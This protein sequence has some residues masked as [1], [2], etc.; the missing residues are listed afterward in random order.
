MKRSSSRLLAILAAMALFIC[1]LPILAEEAAEDMPL[2]EAGMAEMDAGEKAEEILPAPVLEASPEPSEVPTA[3]IAPEVTNEIADIPATDATAVPDGEAVP[4][5]TEEPF[6][7]EVT[8]A[9]EDPSKETDGEAVN[10]E[11][12]GESAAE[13]GFKL[14]AEAVHLGVGEKFALGT[15]AAGEVSYI[16]GNPKIASVSGDGVV[17]AKR[18]GETTILAEAGGFSAECHVTVVKAPTKVTLS[19]RKLSLGVGQSAL[20]EA[21]LNNGNESAVSFSSSKPGVALVDAEGRVEAISVGKATITAKSYNGKKASCTV[22]VLAAPSRI[23]LDSR[24]LVLPAG[25]MRQ[26]EVRL[27]SNAA[28]ELRFS[29]SDEGIATVDAEGRIAACSPGTA[30]IGVESYN[31]L[32]AEC[33][34]AV[35]PAPVQLTLNQD[36]AVLGVKETFRLIPSNDQGCA[37]DYR[38][39]SSAVRV[40]SV[41]DNGLVTAKK[42][43]SAVIT[44]TAYN[45]ISAAC[46]ITVAKAPRKLTMNARTLTMGA[47]QTEQLIAETD[48]GSAGA[49][50]YSSS[51]ADVASVDESGVITAHAKGK[52]TITAKSY[53]GKK[54]SCTVTVLAAPETMRLLSAAS[55]PMGMTL[56]LE[57][58]VDA[59]AMARF[60]FASSDVSVASVDENGVVSAGSAGTAVITARSYNGLQAQCEITVTPAPTKI[61][62]NA[63]ELELG[64]KEEFHLECSVDQG[65]NAGYTFKSEDAKIASV[66]EDGVITAKKTGTTTITVMTFNG[67]QAQCRVTVRKAPASLRLSEEELHLEVGQSVRL[68]AV[69]SSGSAGRVCYSSNSHCVSVDENGLVTALAAG[70]AMVTAESYNGKKASCRVEVTAIPTQILL[71]AEELTLLTGEQVYLKPQVDQ[72]R[73]DSYRFVS[74]DTAVA[75]VDTYGRISA[76]APGEAVITVSAA[77][78]LQAQC[79][80]IVKPVPTQILLETEELLLYEGMQLQLAVRVDQGEPGFCFSSSDEGVVCV[81]ADG[82]LTAVKAGAAE[83]HI[84]TFN[85][86]EAIC[87]VTVEEQPLFSY[88]IEDGACTIT[89]YLGSDAELVIPA[90]IE[91]VPVT[92][93]GA[94]A[95]EGRSDITSVRFE[96]GIVLIGARAFADCPSLRQLG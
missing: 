29:S 91:N 54:A 73:V 66:D 70:E 33:R 53:N 76:L 12:S 55:L 17:T 44:V 71:D 1:G 46:E 96:G 69:L 59:G 20:L 26:L 28:A 50:S 13:T 43:G 88:V 80:V 6:D 15:D 95:F 62:L 74:S 23:E 4:E 40:V 84:A 27:D 78:D 25:M 63:E 58:E 68:E 14:N 89:G 81:D 5:M 31:G 52:A 79:R 10:M 3:E 16:S 72:G 8:E 45:G 93:I 7:A 94:G 64:V 35:I 22:T 75:A 49:I 48:S 61:F 47:G 41:D 24:E 65:E 86:L 60:S 77:H 51:K 30:V 38:F 21:G 56:R 32:R 92:A 19:A 57:P 82:I 37:A 87:R 90:K 9:P 2:M 83:I 36:T 42:A 67:L 34:V 85:G 18:A 11:S 39:A